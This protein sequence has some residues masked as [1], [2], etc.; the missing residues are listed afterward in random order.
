[1]R[2]RADIF[3][4]R[5]ERGKECSLVESDQRSTQSIRRS[6]LA[7]FEKE[8]QVKGALTAER[9][10][11]VL[12]YDKGSGLFTWKKPRNNFVKA[13][14]SA[15]AF[16]QDGYLIIMVDGRSYGAARLAWLYMTGEWPKFEIDHKDTVRTNNCWGNLR[17]VSH[18]VNG[19]N[20]RK[21]P[22]TSQSGVLG[23]HLMA[24][25]GK[26]ASHIR[27]NK[28]LINLGVFDT[29]EQA[30]RAFIDAKRKLHEGNTL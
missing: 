29:A 25:N 19:Q 17:D 11:D 27:V 8:A 24:R 28:K 10:R 4:Y 22:R 20:R 7:I 12:L 15:G 9:L 18:A 26:Y 14:D 30:G 16:N 21:A 1:M 5:R 23:A 3:G 13:G 2:P 6:T